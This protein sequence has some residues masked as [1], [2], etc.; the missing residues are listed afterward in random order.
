MQL[1]FNFSPCSCFFVFPVG[2]CLCLIMYPCTLVLVFLKMTPIMTVSGERKK[3]GSCYTDEES[4]NY[5]GWRWSCLKNANAF[6]PYR[7]EPAGSVLE[8]SV[9]PDCPWMP[10]LGPALQNDVMAYFLNKLYVTS[11]VDKHNTCIGKCFYWHIFMVPIFMCV[12]LYTI[13]ITN[14]L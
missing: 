11:H 5:T 10:N 9:R 12:Y 6:D 2:S 8:K 4:Q 13:Y 1:Y 3:T 14:A 7:I